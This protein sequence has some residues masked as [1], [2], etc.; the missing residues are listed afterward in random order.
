MA[1]ILRLFYTSSHHFQAVG[2]KGTI[3]Q[4]EGTPLGQGNSQ[5]GI[6]PVLSIVEELL[7]PSVIVAVTVHFLIS[8]GFPVSCFYLNL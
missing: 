7:V 5:G 4:E 2:R 8:E 6:S 3:S 1:R